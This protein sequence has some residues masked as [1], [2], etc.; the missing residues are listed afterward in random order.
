MTTVDDRDLRTELDRVRAGAAHD[1]H[2]REVYAGRL[3]AAGHYVMT[4]RSLSGKQRR[5]LLAL[6]YGHRDQD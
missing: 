6:L 1:R 2:T 4:V 5:E 3:N